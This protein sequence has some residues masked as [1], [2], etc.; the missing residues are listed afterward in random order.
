MQ[1][2]QSWLEEVADAADVAD[3]ADAAEVL[4]SMPP[5]RADDLSGRRCG[6]ETQV[7]V[8]SISKIAKS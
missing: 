1:I 5:C 2:S 3:V 8:S 6:G 7:V 4:P